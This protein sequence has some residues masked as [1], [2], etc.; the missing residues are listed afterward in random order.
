MHV[1]RGLYPDGSALLD[2]KQKEMSGSASA[3]IG[4]T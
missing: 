2:I 1:A 4:L 3:L